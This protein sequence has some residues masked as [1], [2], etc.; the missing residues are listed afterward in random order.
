MNTEP[1]ASIHE[2][3]RHQYLG[4]PWN[5]RDQLNRLIHNSSTQFLHGMQEEDFRWLIGQREED[6]LFHGIPQIPFGEIVEPAPNGSI[7][8]EPGR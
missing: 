3:F 8:D 1:F 6:Q 5:Q 2:R 7:A 4:L